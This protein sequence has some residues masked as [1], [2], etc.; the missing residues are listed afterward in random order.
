MTD[1]EK[2]N[3]ENLFNYTRYKD[4]TKDQDKTVKEFEDKYP[5]A[6]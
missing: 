4:R 1:E 2:D 3:L 6:F 5:D